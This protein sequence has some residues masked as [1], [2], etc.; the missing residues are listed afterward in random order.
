MI[1]DLLLFSCVL[2]ESNVNC[3][4][5]CTGPLSHYLHGEPLEADQ[6]WKSNVQHVHEKCI[7]WYATGNF[8]DIFV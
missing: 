3:I 4:L 7:E 1:Y 8:H 2:E 6:A 5:Q